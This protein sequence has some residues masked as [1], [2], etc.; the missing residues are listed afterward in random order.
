MV[1]VIYDTVMEYKELAEL[2][3]YVV[4]GS[5]AGGATVARELSNANKKVLVLERGLEPKKGLAN[6][7]YSIIPSA[8]EIWSTVCIGGTTKVT[9]GNAVRSS[10]NSLAE[11]YES[12]EKDLG[13]SQVPETHIGQATRMLLNCSDDW[14]RM[15]KAIDF[16]KCRMC[17]RC[18]LGCP[19]SAKWDASAYLAEAAHSGAKIS[20]LSEVKRVVIEKNRV[21]GVEDSNG[22]KFEANSVILCAGGIETPES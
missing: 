11:Y 13:V 21:R 19:N 14:I 4:V 5:G 6:S 10:N 7:T 18:A 22:K 15:P 3:D 2:F 8:V 20:D 16:G 17:G 12:A 1:R 9:M